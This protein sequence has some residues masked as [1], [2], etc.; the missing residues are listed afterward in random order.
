LDDTGRGYGLVKLDIMILDTIGKIEVPGGVLDIPG[1]QAEGHGV[2]W[3]YCKVE[4][5][6]KYMTGN[7]WSK[8]ASASRCPFEA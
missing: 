2:V 6:C 8:E 5:V 1:T 3:T 7:T 4:S